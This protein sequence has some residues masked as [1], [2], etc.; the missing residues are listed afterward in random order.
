MTD[1]NKTRRIQK[2]IIAVSL[3]F[4]LL[5]GFIAGK[6]SNGTIVN[7]SYAAE[8]P[9]YSSVNWSVEYVYGHPFVVFTSSNGGIAIIPKNW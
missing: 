9:P 8:L 1:D 7:K 3:A 6:L 2:T 5:L 4:M